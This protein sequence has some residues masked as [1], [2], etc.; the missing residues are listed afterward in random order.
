MSQEIAISTVAMTVYNLIALRGRVESRSELLPVARTHLHGSLGEAQLDAA[1]DGLL[2]RKRIQE[3]EAGLMLFDRR[4]RQVVARDRS[5][6]QI[7]EETGEV[8]GG[9]NG[10]TLKDD[11]FGGRI[12]LDEV[13]R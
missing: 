6:V 12:Q 3:G 9:W 4:R 8:S 5:D 10:W 13:L 7:D 2:S 11:Q 1:I